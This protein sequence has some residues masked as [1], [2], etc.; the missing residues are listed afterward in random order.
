M[1]PPCPSLASTPREAVHPLSN[2]VSHH[3]LPS[4][5][6]PF[7]RKKGPHPSSQAAVLTDGPLFVGGHSGPGHYSA[8]RWTVLVYLPPTCLPTR[9]GVHPPA[10][11][12]NSASQSAVGARLRS[13]SGGCPRLEREPPG[14]AGT[15]PLRA[16]LLGLRET[17]FSQHSRDRFWK[18]F[19]EPGGATE[20]DCCVL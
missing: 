3:L 5:P 13:P 10:V 8:G 11:T 18:L 9:A 7:L 16:S 6:T 20:M 1:L 2:Q 19:L 17:D 15:E 14:P 4:G 12:P